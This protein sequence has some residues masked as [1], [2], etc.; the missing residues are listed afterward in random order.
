MTDFFDSIGHWATSSRVKSMSVF[1]SASDILKIE[2]DVRKV[3][4]SD[5]T[6]ELN[7]AQ[8]SVDLSDRVICQFGGE[9]TDQIV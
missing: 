7:N 1:P 5:R 4:I 6:I 3:P 9:Q 8:T 2:G